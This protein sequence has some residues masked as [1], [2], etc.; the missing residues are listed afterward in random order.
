MKQLFSFNI[1]DTNKWKRRNTLFVSVD[2]L[3]RELQNK[4]EVMTKIIEEYVK[5][6][7]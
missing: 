1:S 2:Y 5:V 3:K 6:V 7:F 4:Y